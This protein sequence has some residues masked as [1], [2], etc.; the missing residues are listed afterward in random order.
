MASALYRHA[1]LIWFRSRG[2]IFGVNWMYK[3]YSFLLL[4]RFLF[5]RLNSLGLY[6]VSFVWYAHSLPGICPRIFIYET[7]MKLIVYSIY[8]VVVVVVVL[9]RECSE[10]THTHI[11][12][13]MWSIN[14]KRMFMR[15]RGDAQAF[16]W[17]SMNAKVYK[18]RQLIKRATFPLLKQ[19]RKCIFKLLWHF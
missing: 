10:S 8:F 11:V 13:S 17:V 9:C 2:L 4:T 6:L 14:G 3:W 1:Y 16:R 7:E 19:M 12:L 15:A 5:I 18:Y